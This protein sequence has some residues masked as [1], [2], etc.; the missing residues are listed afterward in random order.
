[1]Q[2]QRVENET[3]RMKHIGEMI[4]TENR[5]YKFILMRTGEVVIQG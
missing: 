3:R 1:M 4:D 5:G 2:K